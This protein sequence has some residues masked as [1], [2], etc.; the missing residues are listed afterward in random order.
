MESWDILILK[1]TIGK[2]AISKKLRF[3]SACAIHTGR[4]GLIL[5]AK[6]LKPDCDVYK[7]DS[8]SFDVLKCDQLKL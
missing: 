5:F 4:P 2:L 8:T 3:R 6:S 1:M 7:L